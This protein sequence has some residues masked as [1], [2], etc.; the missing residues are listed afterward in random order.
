[1]G[2]F[3]SML[4]VMSVRGRGCPR[5]IRQG[6]R[7]Q[8]L[9]IHRPFIHQ[10]AAT[11][12]ERER[13]HLPRARGSCRLFHPSRVCFKP[14]PRGSACDKVRPRTYHGPAR[15][16]SSLVPLFL[17][18]SLIIHLS[19][20]YTIYPLLAIIPTIAPHTSLLRTQCPSCATRSANKTNSATFRKRRMLRLPSIQS[21]RPN[22]NSAASV[23]SILACNLL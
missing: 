15:Y 21:N 20:S 10:H 6:Q 18:I 13:H 9:P 5:L 4:R 23:S 7:E 19:C 11:E 16:S 17:S 12:R 1:M 14:S 2:Q 22:T 3:P 8:T